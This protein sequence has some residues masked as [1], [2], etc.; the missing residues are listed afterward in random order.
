MI[1]MTGVFK[2]LAD[3]NRLRIVEL[4][5]QGERCGCTLI[6]KLPITQPTLSYH[7]KILTEAQVVDAVREGNMIKHYVRMNTLDLITQFIDEMKTTNTVNC[8][9][10]L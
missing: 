10:G 3:E 6:D 8:E 1:N 2:A 9:V 4:L 5:I 7:L